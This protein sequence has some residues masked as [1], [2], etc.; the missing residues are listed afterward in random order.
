MNRWF[1]NIYDFVSIYRFM[2]IYYITL[3]LLTSACKNDSLMSNVHL[4]YMIVHSI[5][6]QN[7]VYLNIRKFKI[8]LIKTF[9]VCANETYYW[10][11][12]IDK[13]YKKNINFKDPGTKQLSVWVC[14]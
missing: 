14:N 10:R 3:V 11:K 2:Y 9:W 8:Y 1:K 7:V 12:F 6:N 5:I 13:K 4:R